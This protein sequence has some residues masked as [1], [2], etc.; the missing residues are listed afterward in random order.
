VPSS[1]DL[2]DEEKRIVVDGLR[3]VAGVCDGARAKDGS[4][5]SRYDAEIGHDLAM[6]GPKSR[7]GWVTALRL[8]RKYRN[9]MPDTYAGL[10]GALERFAG[11]L[12]RKKVPRA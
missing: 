3:Q 5:F 7:K 9:Q 8:C 1:P 6:H 11:E 4:G 12:V 2:T 10:T